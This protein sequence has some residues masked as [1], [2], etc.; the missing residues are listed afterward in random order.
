MLRKCSSVLVRR[1][2]GGS[3]AHWSIG[4][5]EVGG[6]VRN[7][8]S[9]RSCEEL[10]GLWW[11]ALT[12]IRPIPLESLLTNSSAAVR[13]T[14][15]DKHAGPAEKLPTARSRTDCSGTELGAIMDGNWS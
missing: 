9:M 5:S 11:S 1:G 8:C 7:T 15:S 14:Q 10:H 3:S 4:F 12:S 13:I 2:R 6:G